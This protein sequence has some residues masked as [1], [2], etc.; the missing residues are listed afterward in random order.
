MTAMTLDAIV[1]VCEE[2]TAT[3]LVDHKKRSIIIN[4]GKEWYTCLNKRLISM[5]CQ[6]VHKSAIGKFYT[7]TYLYINS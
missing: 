7:C 5:R 4:V 6:L 3:M 2:F 1:A